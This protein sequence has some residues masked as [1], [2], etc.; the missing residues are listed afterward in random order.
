MSASGSPSTLRETGEAREREQRLRVLSCGR[1]SIARKGCA[2]ASAQFRTRELGTARKRAGIVAEVVRRRLGPEKRRAHHS[3]ELV[4]RR[5]RGPSP[6]FRNSVA[7]RCKVSRRA[8]VSS[9]S[10]S[11][12]GDKLP[13]GSGRANRR[14]F[15]GTTAAKSWDQ[16]VVGRL[17]PSR[18]RGPEGAR[19]TTERGK[20]PRIVKAVCVSRADCGSG[21]GD[22]RRAR[23]CAPSATPRIEG[24][25]RGVR[26]SVVVRCGTSNR[27]AQ[28]GDENSPRTFWMTRR[29]ASDVVKTSKAPC[30]ETR[31]GTD[32][33]RVLV[34]E[35]SGS[36]R[37]SETSRPSSR[38]SKGDDG[39]LA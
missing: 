35:E 10:A 32:E 11:S 4:P 17:L 13:S 9:G 7:T 28:S 1:G 12:Q 39:G 26:G 38:P 20:A 5:D 25:D 21:L 18:K 29:S 14:R 23:D 37:R 34:V 22:L 33:A 31:T 24:S 27:S 2:R 3:T 36:S 19:W 16:R 30:D 15:R 8:F 6:R